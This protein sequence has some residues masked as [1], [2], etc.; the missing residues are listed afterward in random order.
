MEKDEDEEAFIS[1]TMKKEAETAIYFMPRKQ[2]H[3]HVKISNERPSCQASKALDSVA[4]KYVC[5][6]QS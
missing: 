1:K 2:D 6:S 3:T 4:H 5:L